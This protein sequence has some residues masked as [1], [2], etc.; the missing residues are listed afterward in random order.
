VSDESADD[1]GCRCFICGDRL[2]LA[3]ELAHAIVVRRGEQEIFLH[4]DCAEHIA[5]KQNPPQRLAEAG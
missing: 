4:P 1:P 5:R 3:G 2:A